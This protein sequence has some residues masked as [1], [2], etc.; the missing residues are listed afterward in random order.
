MNAEKMKATIIQYLFD[1]RRKQ[2]VLLD[3]PWGCGKSYFVRNVLIPEIES[4]NEC[5]VYLVSL[6]GVDQISAIQDTIYGLWLQKTMSEKLPD[7]GKAGTI[8]S[9]GVSILGKGLVKVIENKIGTDGATEGALRQIAEAGVEKTGTPIIIFDDLER[10]QIDIITLM[11]FINNLVENNDFRVL[12]VANEKEI[13]RDVDELAYALQLNVSL[14][15]CIKNSLKSESSSTTN[16]EPLTSEDIEE[17]RHQLF[18]K[19]TIYDRTREKLI[20]LTVPY[21]P[22]ISDSFDTILDAY[23]KDKKVKEN[24]DSRKNKIIDVFTREDCSNLRTLISAFIAMEELL[25]QILEVMT[26]LSK[27][28]ITPDEI[29]IILTYIAYTSIRNANGDSLHVWPKDIRYGNI[30]KVGLGLN[31]KTSVF[32]YAFIDQYWKTLT[33]DS[34]VVHDDIFSAHDERVEQQ[35]KRDESNAHRNLSLNKLGEWYLLPDSEVKNLVIKMKQELDEKLYYPQEFKEI[36]H[37]LMCINNPNFGL[38]P[39]KKDSHTNGRIY[40]SSEMLPTDE[41]TEEKEIS[42]NINGYEKWDPINIAEYVDTMMNYFDGE[43]ELTK[44]MFRIISEDKN[45]VLRYQQL[46]SPIIDRLNQDALDDIKGESTGTPLSDMHWNEEFYN[47]CIDHKNDYMNNGRFM[48]LLEYDKVVESLKGALPEEIDTLC[49]T[50]HRVYSFS[51][52]GDVYSADYEI[53]HNL[54]EKIKKNKAE[55]NKEKSRTKEIML[56]RLLADLKNYD[57]ALKC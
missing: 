45:Y 51:N 43:H 55:L 4:E 13:N 38:N 9:K 36:V 41:P 54:G 25:H 26:E 8:L 16:K 11:G 20:G 1:E 32:G 7:L 40:D 27:D 42:I 52:L 44:E 39:N 15:E 5:Q 2:A 47:Y 46:I 22:D 21:T 23:I 14:N 57:A 28:E 3:G 29:S 10:C 17:K 49:N 31:N 35:K 37:V 53:V 6:Y 34:K 24:I 30:N 33:F 48:S 56:C 50:L 18:S 19:Q 12:I